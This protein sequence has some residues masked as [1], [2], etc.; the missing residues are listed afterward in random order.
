MLARL[1]ELT[2]S[3]MIDLAGNAFNAFHAVAVFT[4]TFACIPSETLALLRVDSSHSHP[5]PL[6]DACRCDNV[7]T[8]TP[9][10]APAVNDQPLEY[11]SLDGLSDASDL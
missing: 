1:D 7:G 6:D 10:A 8:T 5:L 2:N 11:C 3:Q 9:P 4:A